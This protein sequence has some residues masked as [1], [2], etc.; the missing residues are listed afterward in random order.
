MNTMDNKK[1]IEVME[2]VTLHKYLDKLIHARMSK[3]TLF[4][5]FSQTGAPNL[6]DPRHYIMIN[7]LEKVASL[8]S[9]CLLN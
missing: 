3:A 2:K 6:S 4:T 9:G 7:D 1:V 8:N 5:I